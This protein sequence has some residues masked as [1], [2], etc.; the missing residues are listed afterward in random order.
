[1]WGLV[2]FEI[3]VTPYS[4]T[5]CRGLLIAHKISFLHFLQS[6]NAIWVYGLFLHSSWRLGQIELVKSFFSFFEMSNFWNEKKFWIDKICK[7]GGSRHSTAKG[8]FNITTRQ[9]NISLY[10]KLLAMR[11]FTLQRPEYYLNM[12]NHTHTILLGSLT[13]FHIPI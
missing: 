1:M 7:M 9:W 2:A 3:R 12:I 10:F 5:R 6:S 8:Q 13:V 4:D 11:L